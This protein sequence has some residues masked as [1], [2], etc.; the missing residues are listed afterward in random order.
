MFTTGMGTVPQMVFS[1]STMTIGIPTG[2]KI[3]NW[4]GTMYGGSIRFTTATYY[5][6]AFIALFTIGGISGVMHASPG[7]DSQQ[8]DSYFVVAHIHYVLF[9]G[10]MMGLFSAAYYWF[11]KMSGR[12]LSERIGKVSFWFMFVGINLTFFPMHFLGL[13]GMPR[14]IYT[15]D[16]GMGWDTWNLVASIGSYILGFGV[17]LFVV[18]VVRALRG[19]MNAPDNPWDA[20]SLEWGTSSP[21]PAH[22]FDVTPVV[23]SRDPLWYERDNP[24]DEAPVAR[25]PI[26]LPPPSYFPLIVTL[27]ILGIGV[28]FLSH[29][30]LTG[31][32]IAVLIYGIWG[33]A[34]EPTD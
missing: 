20:P 8:Q 25:G 1:A 30:A 27:G 2:I 21:P 32:G 29:L 14:R 13:S 5:S 23:R 17:L 9:G 10:S 28:G 18:N 24:R 31:V 11:P 15:Y 34:V 4:L 16:S 26:H 6:V 12:F 19:P 7:V 22:N 33:W 3:F